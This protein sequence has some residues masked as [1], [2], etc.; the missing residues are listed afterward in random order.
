MLADHG[1]QR[2][3][4]DDA[5]VMEG[6]IGQE[7][8][9]PE[10]KAWVP[11]RLLVG[12]ASAAVLIFAGLLLHG[13]SERRPSHVGGEPDTQQLAGNFF[14]PVDY[15]AALNPSTTLSP[16]E[17]G[18]VPVMEE[19]VVYAG[20]TQFVWR[21]VLIPAECCARCQNDARCRVWVLDSQT[22][23]CSLK[24][25]E[26]D[27]QLLKVAKQGS[28]SGLPFHWTKPHSMLCFAVMRPGTYEQGLMSWQYKNKANIFACDEWA[29]YSSQ[30]V[31]I[32]EGYLESTVVDSDLKCEMGGEFGTA[33]NTD[34]F[35]KVWD[36]VFEDK[37]Y[38]FHEWIVKADPDSVCIIDRLRVAVAFHHD[39]DKGVYFNNCQ[40]GLHGPIEV[41]SKNAVEAWRK[42]RPHCIKH[43]EKLCSGPC[44]WG[45][46]M[47]IDQCLMKVLDVQ[48]VDDWNLISEAHCDS[49][50][51]TEC[52]NGR[53]CFHP[54]KD[55]VSYK[56]CL[57]DAHATAWTA[58]GQLLT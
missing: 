43:F 7:Q 39:V 3:P 53:I 17:G 2:M 19:D 5:E 54:F 52:R 6:L 12:A 37:R 27:E 25:V 15:E 11:A 29:V 57:D 9:L 24:W 1:S 55:L 16:S 50:D 38:L 45:E 49:P 10:R 36:K 8:Q 21:N 33:L 13:T 32:V 56:R 47:W 48:R 46:D 18:M 34:I 23:E 51:W 14:S 30:K 26:P 28:T 40:F 41:F 44:L 4:A 20:A 58:G 35:F 42:G 22:H 31:E